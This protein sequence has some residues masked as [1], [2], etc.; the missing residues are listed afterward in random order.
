MLGCIIMVVL[1][2]VCVFFGFSFFGCAGSDSGRSRCSGYY[3]KTEF[4]VIL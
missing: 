1:F 2:A 4:D 3:L